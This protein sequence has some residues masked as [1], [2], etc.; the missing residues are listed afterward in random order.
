LG[1]SKAQ[2][3]ADSIYK[4]EYN[5]SE[6][7]GL[8]DKSDIYIHKSHTSTCDPTNFIGNIF[9]VR[10]I[11]LDSIKSGSSD[12]ATYIPS[13]A[14]LSLTNRKH[15]IETSL[16]EV[17]DFT[18]PVGLYKMRISKIGKG[19]INR[20][21][22]IRKH[23]LYKCEIH[24]KSRRSICQYKYSCKSKM[25]QKEFKSIKGYYKSPD[26]H[27]LIEPSCDCIIEIKIFD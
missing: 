2:E 24:L 6:L 1:I 17:F 11:E 10:N 7:A 22:R 4:Y 14:N 18:F 27:D 12:T 19:F 15:K 21:I 9:W 16:D 26:K 8:R 3:R 23:I 20:N 5:F 25:T 13:T